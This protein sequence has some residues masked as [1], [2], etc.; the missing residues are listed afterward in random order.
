MDAELTTIFSSICAYLMVNKGQI[1]TSVLARASYDGLKKV[2]DF[3][4]LKKRLKRFFKKESEVDEYIENLFS[5]SANNPTKPYRDVEDV[6]EQVT[7]NDF[8]SEIF[9]EIAEWIKKNSDQL[10][11][12]SKMQFGNKGGFNIGIQN[13]GKNIFNIQGDYKP[14]KKGPAHED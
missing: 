2:L 3:S 9:D 8:Q 6:Y 14:N 10:I 7:G 5:Q 13:A 4:S 12:V 1:A 11:E